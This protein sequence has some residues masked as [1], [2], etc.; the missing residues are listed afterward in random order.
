MM[1]LRFLG[2]AWVVLTAGIIG[3]SHAK[4]AAAEPPSPAPTPAAIDASITSSR[5]SIGRNVSVDVFIVVTDKSVVPISNLR[6]ELKNDDFS[7]VKQPTFPSVVAPFAS[8][9]SRAT[10][11]SKS[12]AQFGS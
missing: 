2:L 12:S 11:Q 3:L 8:A 9:A 6:V 4:H 1:R 7:M 10:I 5:N